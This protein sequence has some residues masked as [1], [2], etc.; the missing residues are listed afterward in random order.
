MKLSTRL[1]IAMVALVLLMATSMS[2]FIYY[3]V[4]AVALPRTLD[5]LDVHARLLALE[6][7]SSRRGARAFVQGIVATLAMKNMALARA[8]GGVDPVYD[9][10]YAAWRERTIEQFLAEMGP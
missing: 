10:T 4:A 3:N 5:R 2:T 9:L 6:L 7:E 1:A 8:G